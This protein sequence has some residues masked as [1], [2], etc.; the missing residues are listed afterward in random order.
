M[1]NLLSVTMNPVTGYGVIEFDPETF[2][3]LVMVFLA[4]K[5]LSNCLYSTFRTIWFWI[6]NIVYKKNDEII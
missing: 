2:I 5:I 3:G 4:C 1:F 6:K